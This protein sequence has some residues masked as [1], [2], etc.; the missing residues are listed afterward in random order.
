MMIFIAPSVLL[1]L[2]V[3]AIFDTFWPFTIMVVAGIATLWWTANLM[4]LSTIAKP[5]LI[6]GYILIGLAWIFFKW[7]RLVEKAHASALAYKVRFHNEPTPPKWSDHSYDF[8]AYFFYWPLDVISY[9][10]S[11]LVLDA[12]KFV[13]NM[14]GRTFDRYRRV[15][16]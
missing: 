8:S 14:V 1:I 15:A 9:V 7:T 2:V 11:D 12:W 5:I 6:G 3:L 4:V 16:L 10:L 13:S